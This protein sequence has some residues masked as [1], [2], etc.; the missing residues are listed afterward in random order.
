MK[1]DSFGYYL[2]NF[3]S[4][5]LPAEKGK[6]PNTIASYR[7][8]FILFLGFLRD[9]YKLEAHKIKLL[10]INK[11]KV[12]SF[13]QWLEAERNC[14]ASTRNTRLSAIRSFIKYVQYENPDYLS[15]WESVMKIEAKV[16][17]Q[18]TPCYMPAE[19]IKLLLDMPDQKTKSG[20]RDLSMLSLMFDTG[21]RVSEIIRLTPGMVRLDKPQTIKLIG[22]GEKARIV[23]LLEEQTALLTQYM[24]ENGLNVASANKYPLFSN[25][26]GDALTRQ[27]VTYILKK[28][29]KMAIN[30][31]LDG[32][33]NIPK[34][35][36]CHSMRHS[37]A[38]S[39]LYA[40]VDLIY[41]RDM[42]G[43]VSVKTTEVYAKIDSRKK[44]VALEAAYVNT[45]P[46]EE[47][48]WQ[49]DGQLIDWLR[50]FD[51]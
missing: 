15:E 1:N 22:K 18:K 35:F 21:A 14:S 29:L 26:K 4:K 41:I 51:K 48:I 25:R 42:L 9:S 46:D 40:D 24:L 31:G 32:C 49:K 44:R 37:K 33:R 17:E 6:K 12:L 38:M 8:T 2:T 34:D 3:L 10:D 13:L 27:G 43:H 23:P 11:E 28:Y 36:S 7:D 30:S 20:R 19:E 50:G 45:T 16:T 39:L 5:Y 47:P